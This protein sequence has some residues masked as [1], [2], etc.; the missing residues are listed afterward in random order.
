MRPDRSSSTGTLSST[1]ESSG[2]PHS[3]SWWGRSLRVKIIAWFFVPT[4]LL[5]IAVGVTNFFA[6]QDVTADLV[7]ERDQDVT[8]LS[9]SQLST[10]LGEFTETLAEVGRSLDPSQPPG[11]SRFPALRTAGALSVF[12]GGVVVLDTLGTP[13]AALP[14]DTAG[15]F[16]DWSSLALFSELVR[17]G[18]PVFSNVL[19]GRTEDDEVVAIGVAILGARGELLGATVGMFNVGATSVST[20][21]GRIVRLHLDDGG[22]VY[23]VDETGKVIYHSTIAFAGS[24]FSQ[25]VAVERVL[26]SG[27]GALRTTSGAG[28]D[29]LVAYSPVPGTPWSLVSETSWLSLTSGSRGY[30]WLLLVLLAF[31]ILA[32]IAIVGVGIRRL[33]RPVDALIAAARAVGAGNFSR[34]IESPSGDEIGVLATE[35]NKMASALDESYRGLERRVADRTEE[36]R[37]TEERYRT[38]FEQSTDAIFISS[39]DGKILDVNQAALAVF[40]FTRDEAMRVD[41]EDCI[42]DPADR[43]RLRESMVAGGGSTRDFELK[44]RKQDG[45]EMDCLLTV[46]RRQGEEGARGGV[47]G[48][49]RDVTARNERSKSC[50]NRRVR[51]PSWTSAIGWPGRFTIRSP[52]IHRDRPSA[53]S[54]AASAR[55][56]AD[57]SS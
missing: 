51:Q 25:E 34:R 32:P 7:I 5:L 22:L 11:P 28:Q 36:L 15:T 53:R 27:V 10:S 46:R 1:A 12:D 29:V 49:V 54:G 23:L 16:E 30:Q 19:S 31:G 2:H 8:R 6:Y 47:E 40:G 55:G 45:T 14:A 35:F 13:V 39:A 43:E 18:R 9:A 52:G 50:S 20:L 44:L 48:T 26:A 4:A 33:M 41:I 3:G 17:F 24:D 57:G 21:Y 56:A 42:V 37:V 38:L